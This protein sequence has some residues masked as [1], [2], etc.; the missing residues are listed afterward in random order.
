MDKERIDEIAQY[1][2]D[3]EMNLT[4]IE[5]VTISKAPKL[6]A[7]E[8]YQIQDRMTEMKRA[9]GYEVFAPKLGLTSPA[10]MQQ[11]NVTDPI[12]GKVFDYM[13]VENEG[14]FEVKDYI[15]VRVEPEIAVVLKEELKGPGVTLEDVKNAVDYVVSSIELL[16]SRYIDYGF[17]HP[18]VIAD[19]TSARG[20]VFSEEKV[21]L[22]TIDLIEEE[23]KL[24]INGELKVAGTGTA[25]LGN[26]LETL[27]FLANEL[28]KEGEVVPANVPIMTGG[29]TSAVPVNQGDVIE[30]AYTTLGPIKVKAI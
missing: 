30:V 1:L 19:N 2:Y 11:M 20:A 10:K 5:K 16:D 26:P 12:H 25:V 27:V 28:A 8:A 18:D 29:M 24:F 9:D 3:A 22:E 7:E 4:E 21:R 14:T 15:H 6:T 17:T 23:A 13:L